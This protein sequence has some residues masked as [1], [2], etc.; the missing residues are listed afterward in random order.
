M[1]VCRRTSSSAYSRTTAGSSG[2]SP[3]S[4]WA[5]VHYH[6]AHKFLLMAHNQAGIRG[7]G[8]MVANPGAFRSSSA[9][10]D[11]CLR[12]MTDIMHRRRPPSRTPTCYSTSLGSL[13][14]SLMGPSLPR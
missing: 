1:A 14:T 11:G 9:L 12:E 4:R 6:E 10:V 2:L 8:R 13:A 5:L 3:P 7:L